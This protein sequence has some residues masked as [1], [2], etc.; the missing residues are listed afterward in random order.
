V[1]LVGVCLTA[2]LTACSAD[3]PETSDA[4]A[5]EPEPEAIVYRQGVCRG[6]SNVSQCMKAAEAALIEDNPRLGIQRA[7]D[8]LRLPL[9]DGTSAILIDTVAVQFSDPVTLHTVVGT[10]TD[11]FWLVDVQHYEGGSTVLVDRVDGASYPM[12][13]EPLPSPTGSWLFVGSFD[14]E[15]GY[16]PNGMQMFQVRRD[17]VV[18]NFESR[19][20]NWGPTD[21]RWLG[22]SVVEYQRTRLCY[23]RDPSGYCRTPARVRREGLRWI[24]EDL[25]QG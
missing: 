9:R 8:T 10:V 13:I 23:G 17:T 1:R 6:M 18:L 22:D 12:W 5:P 25:P 11:R 7:Q 2:V 16:S 21:A 24:I 3:T 15:A 4:P 20:E 19:P 14:L